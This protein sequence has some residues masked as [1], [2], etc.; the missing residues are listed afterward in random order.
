MEP[1]ASSK[2]SNTVGDLEELRAALTQRKTPISITKGVEVDSE[3]SLCV[4][5][6]VT[7]VGNGN[8]ITRAAGF[9]GALFVV[10]SGATLCLTN[11][12]VDGN[13]EN[14]AGADSLIRL[15]GGT[16]RLEQGAVLQNN[17]A[18]K[19]GGAVCLNG[20]SF[21][22]NRLILQ[23]DAAIQNCRAGAAG[24]GVYAGCCNPSAPSSILMMGNSVIERNTAGLG[25]GIAVCHENAETGMPSGLGELTIKGHA[26]ILDNTATDKGGGIAYLN[27]EGESRQHPVS[28]HL[29]ISE[30]AVL[31]GNQAQTNGGGVYLFASNPSDGLVLENSA[32]I[33]ANSAD[34]GA[35]IY[36][37]CVNSGAD[38]ILSGGE[39]SNNRAIGDGGGICYQVVENT[40]TQK[41]PIESGTISLSGTY[42][43]QNTALN[44]GGIAVSGAVN[45]MLDGEAA[46]VQ[47]TASQNGGGVFLTGKESVLQLDDTAMVAGNKAANG[48]G[49]YNQN[50]GTVRLEGEAKIQNNTVSKVGA[51]IYN[52]GNLCLEGTPKITDGL[53]LPDQEFVPTLS[54]PLNKGAVIQIEASSYVSPSPEKIPLVIGRAN[55]ADY[56]A[57]QDGDTVPFRIPTTGFDG[58][59]IQKGWDCKQ[60]L[61]VIC[62]YAIRYENLLGACQSN[63]EDYTSCSPDILLSAPQQRPGYRFIGW[64]DSPMRGIKISR[65][66]RGSKGDRVFF[67]RWEQA[68]QK[69]TYLPNDLAGPPAQFMPPPSHIIEGKE[70]SLSTNIPVRYGYRFTGWNTKPDGSGTQYLPG[71]VI[72]DTNETQ[73]LYA[74]WEADP[75]GSYFFTGGWQYYSDGL[76]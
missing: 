75:S 56:P 20:T 62:R 12:I 48:G 25:G 64:F 45:L 6:D 65:I 33:M 3:G 60:I 54:A 37:D 4:T 10:S 70:I 40:Q 39:I 66:P 29:H 14:N 15:N 44:G 11:L 68:V 53:Y 71:Q 57:L 34:K 31:S 47:N 7:I 30:D 42:I 16:L 38:L 74:H 52:Q 23:E 59:E 9:S 43:R 8:I 5:Y 27:P 26:R 58:W 69:L 13:Q 73:K 50:Q 19:N 46:V 41:S 28:V 35:G 17:A 72:K 32:K 21:V 63:P 2:M 24:G 49:I 67:A 76:K 51:G 18:I 61:L 55:C 36:L 22:V 1:L